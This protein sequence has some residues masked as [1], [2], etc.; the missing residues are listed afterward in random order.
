MTLKDWI[1]VT[2]IIVAAALFGIVVGELSRTPDPPITFQYEYY[3]SY[4]SDWP[5]T[6]RVE[7]SMSENSTREQRLA[8]D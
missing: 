6:L 2:L 8:S 5:H 7:R 4:E 3:D 1:I